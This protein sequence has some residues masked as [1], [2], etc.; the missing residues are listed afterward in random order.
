[1][2]IQNPY[3]TCQAC[4]MVYP[5]EMGTCPR[6]DDARIDALIEAN[7]PDNQEYAEIDF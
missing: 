5:E 1:M 7:N 3:I 4:E 6:C 2:T